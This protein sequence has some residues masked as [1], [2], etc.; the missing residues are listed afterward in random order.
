MPPFA[1][2]VPAFFDAAL[3]G[4]VKILF[5]I[6]FALYIAFAFIATRQIQIMRNTVETNL[7]NFITLVGWVHL[8]LAVLAFFFVL[9]TL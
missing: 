3:F 2:P 7:S 6:G 9:V 5:L 1:T 8:G 4:F